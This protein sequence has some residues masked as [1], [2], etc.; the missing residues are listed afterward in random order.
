MLLEHVA[1][2]R[3]NAMGVWCQ[4]SDYLNREDDRALFGLPPLTQQTGDG[5]GQSIDD[6]GQSSS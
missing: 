1:R 6:N 4:M 5:A 3:L 2:G